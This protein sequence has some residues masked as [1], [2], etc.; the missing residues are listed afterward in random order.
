M[1][2]LRGLLAVALAGPAFA[3]SEQAA[4]APISALSDHDAALYA[5]A[6]SA[7]E[8]GD[9]AAADA[10]LAQVSDRC[11]AGQVQYLELTRGKARTASYEEL[12]N[13]I[14]NFGD[15]PGADEVY[16]LALRRKP[17]GVLPPT[18]SALSS[19]GAGAAG[20]RPSPE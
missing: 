7:A 8:R 19:A 2:L 18:P 10:S 6:F 9:A 17:A 3:A 20:F 13:W 16:R 1:R 11:L 12:S 4:A 5:A 14:S 15:N